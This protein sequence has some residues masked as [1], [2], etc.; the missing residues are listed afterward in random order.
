MNQGTKC[1]TV[2]A[3]EL[4]GLEVCPAG[5]VDLRRD[6]YQ[7]VAYVREKG[8][9]RT[10]RGNAIPKSAAR[11]LAKRQMTWFRGLEECRFVP[12]P[13]LLDPVELAQRIE[14]LGV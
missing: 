2:S 13:G 4:A 9:V 7:F 12:V 1:R 6:V 5:P 11:Q 10:K 14:Q 3:K 8:L